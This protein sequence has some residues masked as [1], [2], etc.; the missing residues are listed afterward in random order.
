MSIKHIRILAHTENV[1][2]TH[3]FS[4]TRDNL[5]IINTNIKHSFV[6]LHANNIEIKYSLN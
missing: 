3:A 1:V 6:I 4:L 2:K 5:E